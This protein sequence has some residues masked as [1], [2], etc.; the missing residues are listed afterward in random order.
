LSKVKK[1]IN[2]FNAIIILFA[3]VMMIGQ[4]I[5]AGPD[6]SI[7]N[8]GRIASLCYPLLTVFFFILLILKKL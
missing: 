2:I 7:N 8:V 4:P 3:C 5:M 6:G 1:D